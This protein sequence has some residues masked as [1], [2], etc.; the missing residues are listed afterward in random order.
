MSFENV[1]EDVIVDYKCDAG[2][3]VNSPGTIPS[4]FSLFLVVYFRA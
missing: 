2:I 1:E 4:N 3:A